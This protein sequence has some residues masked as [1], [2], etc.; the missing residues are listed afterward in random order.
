LMV[1]WIVSVWFPYRI[2]ARV[3]I[4]Q[5][6]WYLQQ[7]CFYGSLCLLK[8]SVSPVG[9]VG[10]LSSIDLVDFLMLLIPSRV[11][12]GRIYLCDLFSLSGFIPNGVA[13]SI[14][15]R[16]ACAAKFYLCVLFP[17]AVLACVVSSCFP[18]ETEDPPT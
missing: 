5:R 1:W 13:D 10:D 16:V 17:S 2:P 7:S 9:S 8:I 11:A 15:S 3:G 14:P 6:S 18:V 12:C 4:P